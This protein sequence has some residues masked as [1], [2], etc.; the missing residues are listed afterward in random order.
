MVDEAEA[1][2][3]SAGDGSSAADIMRRATDMYK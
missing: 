1:D 2:D 3:E